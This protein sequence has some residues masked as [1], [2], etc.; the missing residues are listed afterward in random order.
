MQEILRDL[1]AEQ[2][3]LDHFL[4]TL[5][6]PQWDLPSP[7]EGWTVKDSVAHIAHID[8]VAVS[9]LGGDYRP[10][11][12]A[13]RV[14]LGFTEIGPQKGRAM[15]PA[16]V[17][18]WWREIRSAM[19]K[20]LFQCDP[21]QRIPWFAMPMGARAFATARLMETWAHGLDCFDAAGAE[22][23]DTDR[24]RHV[25]FLAYMARPYAYQ[26]NGLAIPTT[27]LRIELI[28]PSG[29]SWAQGPEDVPDRIRGRAGEFCR[30]AVR[31]RNW[32]DMSLEIEGE[33]AKR[34]MAIVQTYAGPPGSGRK[35]QKGKFSS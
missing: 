5:S 33:E 19:M 21:K 1:K 23:E 29:S 31:R 24:L 4:G 16:E 35:P 12:E 30:V 8:E 32:R 13:A 14:K 22:P 3:T 10:L 25:A 2:E 11:E 34:F 17:L 15:K 9:L 28:L 20:E 18:L 6:E 7:A 27:P 26:V